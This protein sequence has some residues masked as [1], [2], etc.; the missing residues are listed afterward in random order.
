MDIVVWKETGNNSNRREYDGGMRIAEC[1][2]ELKKSLRGIALASGFAELGV[3]RARALVAERERLVAWLATGRHGEMQWLARSPERRA[4]PPPWARSVVMLTYPYP[5][6]LFP[7][8][9]RRYAAYAEGT[10]YHEVLPRLRRPLETAIAAAGGRSHG[11]VDSGA[12]MEKAWAAAAGLGFIGR[13]SLLVSHTHGPYVLLAGI[14]TDLELPPDEPDSGGC[15]DCRRCIESCPAGALDEQGLDARR[16]IAYLTIELKR[17]LTDE[18]RALSGEW[19]FGCD[20]CL[21]ACPHAARAL[22][23]VPAVRRGVVRRKR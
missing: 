5:P 15:G 18:E 1:G 17:P 4:S 19:E 6:L 20:A 13:H 23:A 21:A 11:F 8:G 22:P 12:V 7:P 3:A 14:F 10:D 16:C 2:D 9:V